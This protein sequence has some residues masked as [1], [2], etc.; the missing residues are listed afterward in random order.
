LFSQLP[1]KLSPKPRHNKLKA[2][3]QP[4]IAVWMNARLHTCGRRK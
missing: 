3:P 4:I 2:R 1:E